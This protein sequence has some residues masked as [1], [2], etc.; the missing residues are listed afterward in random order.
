MFKIISLVVREST[1]IST[2]S[3]RAAYKI[4]VPGV[5][6]ERSGG[7]ETSVVPPGVEGGVQNEGVEP[8][9]SSSTGSGVDGSEEHS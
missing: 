5:R 8:P 7:T 1:K 6:G 2:N 9:A 4:S 3:Q